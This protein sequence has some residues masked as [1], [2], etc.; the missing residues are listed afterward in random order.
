[1]PDFDG[2]GPTREGPM[3]GRGRGY[4]VEPLPS[5]RIGRSIIGY[6]SR[7][8]GR[9]RGLPPCGPNGRGLG[10]GRFGRDGFR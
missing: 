1:M 7:P 2:T 9:G 8:C 4:C 10:R 3:T 5:R 6:L